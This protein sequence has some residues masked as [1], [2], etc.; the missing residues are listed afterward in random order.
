M[1][2][3]TIAELPG[4]ASWTVMVQREIAE[5]L[6]AAPGSRTYGAASAM[7]Q[8]ACEV[9]LLRTGRPGGLS[10]ASAG[11]LRDLAPAPHGPRRRP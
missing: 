1:I 8:I 2:L 7:A 11:G 4:V 3:R 5:R 9:E 6:R 10:P